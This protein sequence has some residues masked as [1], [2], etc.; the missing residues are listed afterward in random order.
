[1]VSIYNNA[2]N[3]VNSMIKANSSWI[4]TSNEKLNKLPISCK[5]FLSILDIINDIEI[6]N[7]FSYM[8]D[9][10]RTIEYPFIKEDNIDYSMMLEIEQFYN[11]ELNGNNTIKDISKNIDYFID[12]VKQSNGKIIFIIDIDYLLKFMVNLKNELKPNHLIDM[13]LYKLMNIT[14]IEITD[15]FIMDKFDIVKNHNNLFYNQLEMCVKKTN[16]T[17]TN[18]NIV[19][20]KNSDENLIENVY[21]KLLESNIKI[22]EHIQKIKSPYD[23]SYFNLVKINDT[24]CFVK[25]INI[26]ECIDKNLFNLDNKPGI[27][28]DPLDRFNI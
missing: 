18:K 27:I 15:I 14:N 7:F 20:Y 16:L 2:T 23:N 19:V 4:K 25:K 12:I 6:G 1:M 22:T 11:I 24:N 5:Y 13:I 10:T 9:E 28:I 21:W 17:Y 8:N 3:L 26:C